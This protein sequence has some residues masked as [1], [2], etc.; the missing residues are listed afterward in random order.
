MAA[1]Q[2][3]QAIANANQIMNLAAQLLN[4]YSQTQAVNANWQDDNSLAV[5][6]AMG[7]AK[8]NTDG[9]IG[10]GDT[11]PVSGNPLDPTKYPTLSHAASVSQITS[12][13]TQLNNIV[14]YINGQA[15]AATPG[16]RTV[17]NTVSGG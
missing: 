16:V 4:I 6:N 3:S 9:T 17:L 13:L 14:N 7:T 2:Q 1:T 10:A 12:A 15:L 5:M 11:T 8:Q